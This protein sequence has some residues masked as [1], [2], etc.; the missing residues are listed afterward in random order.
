MS[1]EKKNEVLEQGELNESE[2]DGVAGGMSTAN[3]TV[4][5]SNLVKNS[6]KDDKN[7][8][9]VNKANTMTVL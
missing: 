4:G 8:D 6:R 9:G 5:V 7:P 2:L 1:E 3:N